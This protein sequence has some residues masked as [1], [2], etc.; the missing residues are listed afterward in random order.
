M[1]GVRVPLSAAG[2]SRFGLTW[3]GRAWVQALE[4]RSAISEGRLSR[5]R[6]YARRGA[7]RTILVEPGR[8]RAS[9]QGSDP[10]PYVVRVGLPVLGAA[11]WER[12]LDTVAAQAGHMAALLDGELPVGLADDAEQADVQLLP[13]RGELTATCSCPDPV[14]PCKHAAAVTYLVA[15]ALDRDP[16]LLL[17]FRGRDR[18]TIL[19]ELRVRRG[20]EA[21]PADAA[22]SRGDEGVLAS[23]AFART[24]APLP[25]PPLPG[26]RP[27]RP[28]PPTGPAPPGLDIAELTALATDAAAHAHELATGAGEGGLDLDFDADLGRFAS[29]MFTR[30][31]EMANLV[32]R[33]GVDLADLVTRA[34]AWREA[35]PTHE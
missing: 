23:E 5:G 10:K 14:V 3:W 22:G 8:V 35:H 16:F 13:G 25:V 12:L 17:L 34:R 24:P 2:R 7:A 26:A 4:G 1:A 9:V 29:A 33:A 27:G 19:K 20:G 15:D 11:E 32:H 6:T 30:A 18:E 28:A 21:G 31:G